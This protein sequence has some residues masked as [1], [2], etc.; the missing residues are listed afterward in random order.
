MS[1]AT[2]KTEQQLREELGA[3][4]RDLGLRTYSRFLLDTEIGQMQ[5]RALGL[6]QEIMARQSAKAALE[7]ELAA[8]KA[9]AAPAEAEAATTEEATNVEG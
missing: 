6:N 4:I 3:I 7:A 5:Q 2:H 8:E 1:D 9:A